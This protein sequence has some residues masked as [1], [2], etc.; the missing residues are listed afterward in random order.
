MIRLAAYSMTSKT[1]YS[2]QLGVGSCSKD[3]VP[4][5]GN[6]QSTSVVMM[7]CIGVLDSHDCGLL[8]C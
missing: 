6:G 1:P 2:T 3:R 5:L 7:T 8:A 4:R